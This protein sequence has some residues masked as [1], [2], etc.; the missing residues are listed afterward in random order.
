VNGSA[1]DAPP[2]PHA[3]AAAAA[4][5]AV[6]DLLIVLRGGLFWQPHLRIPNDLLAAKCVE[7]IEALRTLLGLDGERR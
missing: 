7:T 6:S 1:P 4:Q 2:D 5:E 3:N